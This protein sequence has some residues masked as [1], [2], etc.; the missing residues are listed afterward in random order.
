MRPIAFLTMSDTSGFMIYDQLLYAPL[1][2]RGFAVEAV[3]WDK[4]GVDWSRFEAVVIRSP[5]DYQQRPEAFMQALRQISAQT[6]LENPYELVAWNIHKGYLG[7]LE[8]RGVPIVPTL[9]MDRFEI[10]T[11]RDYMRDSASR[12]HV[13]KPAVSANADDTYVIWEGNLNAEFLQTRFGPRNVLLQPF[14]PAIQSEGEFSA[15]FFGSDLSHIILKTPRTGDFRVQEEH[16]GQL[17]LV[18]KPESA[19]VE[20][21]TN[22]WKAIMPHPLYGRVDLVRSDKGF[23]LMEV[24]LI[25]PSLYFNMDPDSPERFAS[26]FDRWMEES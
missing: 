22:C 2:A 12:K 7:D 14:L 24:E 1:S 13:V 21:A 16:G 6:R 23:L 8:K 20:A 10:R 17:R 25:E 18:R 4:T 11:V 5:W 15:F 3:A 9:F 19:L 26:V